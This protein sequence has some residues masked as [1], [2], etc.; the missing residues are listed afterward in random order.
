VF[1]IDHATPTIKIGMNYIKIREREKA[2]YKTPEN[3][4]AYM[5]M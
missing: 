1:A 2:S 5:Y 4:H 3:N